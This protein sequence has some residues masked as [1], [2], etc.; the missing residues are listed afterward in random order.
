MV[1]RKGH[2]KLPSSSHQCD[3]LFSDPP[4]A[5]TTEIGAGLTGLSTAFWLTENGVKDIVVL[6]VRGVAEGA[7]G[8]NGGHLWAYT[9]LPTSD[10]MK[11]IL[12]LV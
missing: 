11:A 12:M 3:F 5:S 6:D 4:S 10:G 7:T 9:E 2:Q 1:E 8:R